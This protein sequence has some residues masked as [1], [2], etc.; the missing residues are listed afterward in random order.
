MTDRPVGI[1]RRTKTVSERSGGKHYGGLFLSVWIVAFLLMPALAVAQQSG[2]TSQTQ[3][4][5]LADQFMR[6]GQ[7][8][9]AIPVLEGLYDDEPG[10]ATFYVKLKEAYENVKQYDDAITLV[11]RR[12]E[13]YNTPMLMSEKAR[14]LY[15]A[16]REDEAFAT[17][18]RAIS[19]APE[20]S[21]TYRIV[22]RALADIRRFDRAIDVLQRGR[23]ALDAPTAF[24]VQIAYLH[25]LVGSHREAMNEY[26]AVLENDGDRLQFVRSRLRPFVEQK[27]GLAPSIDVL[28][29]AVEDDPLNGSFRELLAWLHSENGNYRAAL[30]VYRAIDRLEKNQGQTLFP[31]AQQAADAN[32]FAVATDAYA[33]I[34]ERYPDSPV[35]PQAQRGLGDMYRHQ[36]KQSSE[37]VF[38]GQGTRVA[39]PNYES[40]R[41]AYRTFL[42]RY[43]T[44][45]DYASVLLTLGR[46]QMDVFR[47][48]AAAKARL[49]EVVER[50]PG[51]RPANEARYD[52]GRL[53]LLRGDLNEA[54]LAFSRLIESVRTGEL[55]NRA[56]YEMAVLDFYDGAFDAAETRLD[57]TDE[58]TSADVANDAIALGVLIRSNRGPDSTDTPL[59]L[60]ANARLLDRQRSYSAALG[61]LDSLLTRFGQHSLA[62]DARIKRAQLL[63]DQGKMQAAATAFAE[64][65]LIHPRS[66]HADRALFAA[67]EAQESL[68]KVQ[69]AVKTYNRLLEQYPGSLLAADARSRLRQLFMERDS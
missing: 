19:L 8:E 60:Y 31:F 12:L 45:S 62:D 6:A 55:A 10:N 18:D 2:N 69:D 38:D 54:R 30:D 58:N 14:L 63:R 56:R 39:A 52:L 15:L 47:D 42:D 22:Y 41:E 34:L 59:R 66:P 3:R 46:M 21:S 29:E 48:L 16:D 32:A 50:D 43:P 68:G 13:R 20:R 26:V 37:R 24:Q 7:Y 17:W 67:G 40:A 49:Q 57:A 51:S 1:G 11:D 27:E 33:E 61:R 64:L 65:P 28:Q 35:A 25:S 4:F 44:H 5:Q 9:R 53:A 36:A 23:E